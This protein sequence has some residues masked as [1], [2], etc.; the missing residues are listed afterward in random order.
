MDNRDLYLS[1]ADLVARNAGN[2]RS[3]EDFLRALRAALESH[4]AEPAITPAQFVA[5]LEAG[6]S[7]PVAE[8][9]A[10]WRLEDLSGGADDSP[11]DAAAV[12][13]ILKCQVLDMEDAE[14][15]GALADEYRGFGRSVGRPEGTV[16]ATA[17][18]FYNWSPRTYV[19]CGIAGAFGGWE[20]GDDTGRVLVSGEVAV[21]TGEGIKS[22]PAEE[23]ESPVVE[24]SLLSWEQVADFLWCG[25]NYE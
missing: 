13:R 16:R 20:P 19:E 8:R 2:G 15:S 3:L 4:H 11:A 17:G 9:D 25:Q 23:I 22:V 24:L 12:D 18:Y 1:V 10:G 6:F 14:V 21:L 7:D 5:A